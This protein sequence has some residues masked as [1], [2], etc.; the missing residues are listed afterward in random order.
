MADKR[1]SVPK[2]VQDFVFEYISRFDSL[3][4]STTHWQSSFQIMSGPRAHPFTLRRK[5]KD[6]A[7]IQGSLFKFFYRTPPILN[8]SRHYHA[9]IAPY[10]R[11]A[12]GAIRFFYRRETPIIRATITPYSR[13]S[14][15]AIIILWTR[16][17]A[18]N[19][20]IIRAIPHSRF[21]SGGHE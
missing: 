18:S 11:H 7:S 2:V 10:S 3:A 15:G 1:I 20:A 9:T 4:A 16:K 8:L 21:Y 5:G 6:I 14:F 19:R 17:Q 13:H 12:D